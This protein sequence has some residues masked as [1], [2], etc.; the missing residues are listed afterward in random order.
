MLEE[1]NQNKKKKKINNNNNNKAEQ[2]Q[3]QQQQVHR[4]KG[5]DHGTVLGNL[6]RSCSTTNS[7]EGIMAISNTSENFH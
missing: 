6:E 4:S 1:K 7:S 2:K 5:D 3:Q